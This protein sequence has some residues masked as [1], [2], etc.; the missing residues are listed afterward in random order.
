MVEAKCQDIANFDSFVSPYQG[1]DV[2]DNHYLMSPN[3]YPASET[4]YY[5][6][7]NGHA[8]TEAY[9]ANFERSADDGWYLDSEATHHLTNN[10]ENMHF[11]E[12]YKGTDQFII[13]NGQGL[14]ISHIG[15]AFY[16]LE[17]QSIIIHT[18]PL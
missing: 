9:M 15:L 16:H 3:F 10:M 18:P 7:A 1:Y 8:P 6:R 14:S 13:G 11:K 4:S 17:L 5:Y 12:K 2:C